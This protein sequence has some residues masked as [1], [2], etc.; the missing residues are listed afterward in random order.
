MNWQTN[1]FN[2]DLKAVGYK[3]TYHIIEVKNGLCSLK[4]SAVDGYTHIGTF[5][6]DDALQDAKDVVKGWNDN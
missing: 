3:C 4:Q 5:S 2:S 1:P 6:G